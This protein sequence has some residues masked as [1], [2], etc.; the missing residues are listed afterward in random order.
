[1]TDEELEQIADRIADSKK[2]RSMKIPRETILDLLQIELAKRT[3]KAE[4][5]KV[6]KEKLHNIAA[7]YLDGL[8]YAKAAQELEQTF[9]N[10]GKRSIEDICLQFLQ[11]HHSTNERIPYMKEFYTTI[12]NKIGNSCSILDLACG[13]NP[14][15]I[16]LVKFPSSTTYFAYDIHTPRIELISRFFSGIG[17]SGFAEVR[18]ILIRPPLQKASSA[19]LFKEAHRMEKRRKGATRDLIQSLNVGH[20]FIS[21]PNH[22]LNGKFDLHNRMHR[23]ILA[24]I[25]GL[26]S[27]LEIKDFPSETLYYVG[28]NHGKA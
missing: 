17:M 26:G 6:A 22:S 11:A 24:S 15:V 5:I 21:L 25:Q 7:P 4:A 12:F 9:S 13:L 2:Y 16:P 20:L 27:I 28:I 8:N 10:K 18:D 23:L 19:F 1:M 14:F 3:K